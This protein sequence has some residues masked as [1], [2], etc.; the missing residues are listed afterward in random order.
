MAEREEESKSSL[1]LMIV[2]VLSMFVLVAL[3]G[4]L[5][6]RESAKESD[7]APDAEQKTGIDRPI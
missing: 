4:Y 7:L 6:S 1:S 5:L 3:F 2:V